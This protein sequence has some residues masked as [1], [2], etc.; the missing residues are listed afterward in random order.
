MK[1]LGLLRYFL[2]IEIDRTSSGMHITQHKYTLDLLAKFNMLH[3][4]PISTPAE[5]SKKLSAAGG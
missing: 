3:C 5:F 1:D 2:G 4:K